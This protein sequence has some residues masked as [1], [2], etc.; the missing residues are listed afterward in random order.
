MRIGDDVDFVS[1]LVFNWK[2]GTNQAKPQLLKPVKSAT[3]NLV[4]GFFLPGDQIVFADDKIASAELLPL[5]LLLLLLLKLF[6]FLLRLRLLLLVSTLL[7][8]VWSISDL[9]SGGD[10]FVH[11]SRGWVPSSPSKELY[12]TV[13]NILWKIHITNSTVQIVLFLFW[14]K[15]YI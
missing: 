15:I 10:R 13:N 1:V 7:L 3:T 11:K 6:I 8:P 4:R 14:W 9:I 2:V 5:L 12:R